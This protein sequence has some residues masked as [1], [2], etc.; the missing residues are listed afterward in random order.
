VIGLYF[1]GRWLG[2]FNIG[3]FASSNYSSL[4][5]VFLVGLTAGVS[6]C[7]ALVGGL[8]LGASARFAKQKPLATPWEKF[9]P[10]IFFTIG[11]IIAFF[12]LGGIIGWGGS[13]LQL[14]LT[15][16]S[17]EWLAVCLTQKY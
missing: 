13:I 3:G 5:V 10:H 7:M 17:L 2:I 8:V 11:R 12:I 4:P 16:S 15:V 6:T 1:I 14:S 9:T